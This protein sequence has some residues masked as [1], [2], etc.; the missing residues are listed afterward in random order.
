MER[1][2]VKKYTQYIYYL[3]S[4]WKKKGMYKYVCMLILKKEKLKG[5]YEIK[6][7]IKKLFQDKSNTQIMRIFRTR[8]RKWK[9]E[10]HF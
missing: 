10:E 7:K 2:K 6:I 5:Q 8:Q 3:C 9:G 4:K 1:S